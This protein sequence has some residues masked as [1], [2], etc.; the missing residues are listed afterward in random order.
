[1]RCNQ[2]KENKMTKL[3]LLLAAISM[4]G[5]ADPAF[6]QYLQN[7]QAAIATMPNGPAKFYEQARLDEQVLAD[8]QRKQQEAANAAAAICFGL[9]AGANAYSNAYNASRPV[10]VNVWHWR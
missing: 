3:I 6:Q 2:Q 8:R 7:R 9:A 1:M 10:N 4:V 5:C